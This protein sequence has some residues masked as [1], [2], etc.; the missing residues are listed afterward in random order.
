MTGMEWS[1]CND[2]RPMIEA[3]RRRGGVSDR[4]WRLFMAAFW[5]GGRITWQKAATR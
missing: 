2:P 1:V 3:L 5:R 4:Q